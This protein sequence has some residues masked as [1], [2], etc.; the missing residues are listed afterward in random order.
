MSSP[1][2]ATDDPTPV[3]PSKIRCRQIAADDLEE[4]AALLAR[5]FP[6]R[7][8]R[9]WHRGLARLAERI[10]PVGRPRFGFVL[11]AD[12]IL[13]GTLIMIH[14]TSPVA[15]D[16]TVRCNLSSWC[17]APAF[18]AYA[19]L[20]VHRAT[21]SKD[22]V[23]FNIS[24]APWTVAILAAQGFVRYNA[25]RFFA[26]PA[27]V[28]DFRRTRVETF[29]DAAPAGVAPTDVEALRT[30]RGRGCLSL[31]A[32]SGDEVLPFAF[33]PIV[34]KRVVPAALVVH[35]PSCDAF[36]R[37]AGALGRS[38]ALRGMPLVIIDGDTPPGGV[39][40]LRRSGATPMYRKGPV[41]PAPW[42]LVESEWTIFGL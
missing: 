40:G 5:G 41:A 13:V 7:D 11:E 34:V 31:L 29:T 9:H 17:V 6:R 15:G 37:V 28:P 16:R 27:L 19:A 14:G 36:A 39:P 33:L 26:V 1:R 32:H 8:I 20:M 38:L 42:D 3:Q 30:A 25:D 35:A 4:V 2:S 12:G 10:C 24:P 23:Y 22:V 21:S 18:R